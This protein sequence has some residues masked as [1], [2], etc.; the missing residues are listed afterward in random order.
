MTL[1]EIYYVGQSIAAVAIIGSL[2]AL[3]AQ[4]YAAQKMVRDAAVRNQVEGPQNISRAIFE[5][6]GMADVWFRG[7]GGLDH[8]SNED[9]VKYTAFYV[10]SLRIWE[11]LYAHFR[12]RQLGR[13]VWHGH[14]QQLRGVQA[15][16]GVKNVWELRRH[17]FSEEFRQFYENNLAQDTAQD[18]YGFKDPPKAPLPEA[19]KL[20]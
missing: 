13:E 6:P 19:E 18:I 8:L 15:F 14:I 3:M 2:L 7:I 4:N 16:E 17:T 5:T 20:T 12:Y 9:R 1:E 11:G 10:Y